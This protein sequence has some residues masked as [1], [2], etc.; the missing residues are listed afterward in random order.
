VIAVRRPG[1]ASSV[2]VDSWNTNAQRAARSGA[3]ADDNSVAWAVH[4]TARCDDGR[5]QAERDLAGSCSAASP[6]CCGDVSGQTT[7]LP[8]D[9]SRTILLH[10]EGSLKTLFLILDGSLMTL[11]LLD[12][13]KLVIPLLI[14]R[15]WLFLS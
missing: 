13:S 4:S 9:M 7:L 6:W 3:R 1:L 12:V 11:L 8:S 14:C 10:L 5:D 15:S 2:P